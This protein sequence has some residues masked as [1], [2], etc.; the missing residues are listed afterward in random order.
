MISGQWTYNI[1]GTA[2]ATNEHFY[3][4]ALTY[5]NG[6]HRVNAGYTKTREGHNCVGGVCRY[7]PQQQGVMI[8]YTFLF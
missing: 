8:N 6:A 3:T 4:A 5:T 2:E 7:V 1:A